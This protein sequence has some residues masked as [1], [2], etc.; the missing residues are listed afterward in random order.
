MDFVA[1]ESLLF[2]FWNSNEN[3]DFKTLKQK[4]SQK[5]MTFLNSFKHNNSNVTTKS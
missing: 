2:F 3:I 1:L 5:C 4:P